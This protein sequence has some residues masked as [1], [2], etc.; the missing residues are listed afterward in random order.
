[1]TQRGATV[2]VPANPSAWLPSS[3][4]DVRRRP[5]SE[6][7]ADPVAT[8]AGL[9]DR[10]RDAGQLIA[11]DPVNANRIDAAAGFRHLL[12]LLAV[13][14]EEALYTTP[15]LE[16]T[17][18]TTRMDDTLTWG[19]EC[20]DCLYTRA[21]LRE[22]AT[23]RLRGNRGTARYVGLQT[24]DGIASTANV[25]VDEL[26]PDADGHFEVILSPTPH[27][28]NWMELAGKFPNLVVRHF[29]YDWDT[30][31]PSSLSLEVLDEGTAPTEVPGVREPGAAIAESVGALGDFV[32]GNLG[33]F[34]DFGK[35]AEPNT[36]MPAMDMS[37]IGAASEN[38][39]VI[40]K[41]QLADDEALVLEVVP[42]VGVYWSLALGNPWWETIDY[43]NRQSSL[44]GGQAVLD[45]DGAFRA[46]LSARD[47]GVANWL[48]T[49]GYSN[50]PM[51]LRCV[52]TESAPVPLLKVVAFDDIA[53]ALP[54][55]TRRVT[56]AER[57]A[58]L[59][60]RR[61]AV[62]SRFGR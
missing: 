19:M 49:A 44:N 15:T 45:S 26:A 1:M 28:G 8:W 53:D 54:A 6:V 37:G 59:D 62:E 39:P 24:M 27:D 17:V 2:T 50:G 20:P 29:F 43:R 61:R 5:P 42:P 23:Y 4:A 40:G 57:A 25:L 58:T 33:F 14:I 9:L 52:R 11:Q 51:I 16:P 10:L 30:E 48:D 35:A 3:I 34:L 13:G 38:R 41:W 46:V 32:A 12:V 21:S 47:P 22:G 18:T 55:D 60:A 36:F 7:V 56:P 31:V